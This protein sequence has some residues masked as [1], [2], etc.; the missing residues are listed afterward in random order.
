MPREL[1]KKLL[2]KG[3]AMRRWSLRRARQLDSA[4]LERLREERG[5]TLAEAIA[6]PPVT[7]AV[8][9]LERVLFIGDCMWEPNELFPELRKIC[10]LNVL[11]LNP[12]LSDA[13]EGNPREATLRAIEKYIDDEKRL[14]PDAIL[15]YA[16]PALLSSE[17]F[18]VM[19]QRWQCPLLGLNLDDRVEFFPYG[20]LNSGN[21]GYEE[22]IKR[23][24]MNLTSSRAALDWYRAR[25]A[26]VRHMPQGFRRDERFSEP[27][28]RGQFERSFS[29]VGSRKPER[30]T[31]IDA[32]QRHGVE[33][34]TFGAGW[35][36]GGWVEDP[37]VVFRESQMSLGIGYATASAVLTQPKGRD[38]ECPAV[39]SC[40]LTTY[41]WE[42][43]ELFDIGH[44]ILCYRN[45]EE[46]LEIHGYYSRR[47]GECL[48]IA[49]AAH[50]RC[51][52]EHTWERRLREVFRDLGFK[53]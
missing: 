17:V 10:E 43:A 12:A 8:G 22:W 49:R 26:A 2:L 28:G 7:R 24:D 45:V 47:P 50:R 44:E 13:G 41:N 15:F 18:D 6:V 9:A 32:L 30:A 40:Y 5:S 35:P 19:R 39:G 29:F 52:A 14:E 27:P 37:A 16:R 11:D 46:L 31:V 42:L 33:I 4:Y 1:A 3:E 34:A 21:D 38:I 51:Q 48:K 36:G 23:F 20:I 53:V 25:G